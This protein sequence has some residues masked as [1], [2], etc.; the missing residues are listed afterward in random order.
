MHPPPS[1]LAYRP[2]VVGIHVAA[3]IRPP[4]LRVGAET[5][6]HLARRNLPALKLLAIAG[7]PSA[8]LRSHEYW[9]EDD[10]KG[11]KSGKDN[12]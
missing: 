2:V 4:V 9:R 1:C 10:G 3:R 5:N 7:A 12:A 11:K 8:G 6:Q